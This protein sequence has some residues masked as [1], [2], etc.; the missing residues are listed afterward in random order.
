MALVW[1]VLVLQYNI[2]TNNRKIWLMPIITR[3]NQSLKKMVLFLKW[4][5]V[6]PLILVAILTFNVWF[7]L[8]TEFIF[9]SDGCGKQETCEHY[10]FCDRTGDRAK[11]ICPTCDTVSFVLYVTLLIMS[12]LWHC[13]CCLLCDTFNYVNTVTL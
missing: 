12:L 13:N 1:K 3:T 10:S 11:C 6:E 7:P 9:F 4:N 8:K 2:F 5:V